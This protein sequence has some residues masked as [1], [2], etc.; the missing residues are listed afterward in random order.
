MTCGQCAFLLVPDESVLSIYILLALIFLLAFLLNRAGDTQITRHYFVLSCIIYSNTF[1]GFVCIY[2]RVHLRY[3]S[4]QKVTHTF[5]WGVFSIVTKSVKS[6]VSGITLLV[7]FF[8]QV[9]SFKN[10]MWS[11]MFLLFCFFQID[12]YRYHKT[13]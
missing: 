1:Y 9:L 8:F 13:I 4:Q 2:G 7:Y 6:I 11:C 10:S 5:R 12:I 3:F